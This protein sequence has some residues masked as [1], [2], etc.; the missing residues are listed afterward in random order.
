MGAKQ[1]HEVSVSLVMLWRLISEFLGRKS[2]LSC[3]RDARCVSVLL[4]RWCI[5]ETPEKSVIQPGVMGG[6]LDPP[7]VNR[8]TRPIHPIRSYRTH[9]GSGRNVYPAQVSSVFSREAKS[10][11]TVLPFLLQWSNESLAPKVL[12]SLTT[13]FH[14]F[15]L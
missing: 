7:K 3:E 10:C 12:N 1:K 4:H 13:L 15:Q 11:S 6:S 8:D 9:K 2:E 14:A 5:V